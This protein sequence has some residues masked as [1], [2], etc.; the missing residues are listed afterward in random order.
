MP[1]TT[2]PNPGMLKRFLEGKGNHCPFCQSINIDII[3]SEQDTHEVECHDC[4][5]IWLECLTVTG[6]LLEGP[7]DIPP[8][9]LR[10]NPF[11]N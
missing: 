6:L 4:G 9:V 3:H 1:Y 8:T 7:P 10:S 11:K 5:E 2:D